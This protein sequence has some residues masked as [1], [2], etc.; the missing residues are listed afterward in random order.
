MVIIII[1]IISSSS[2]TII[3]VSITRSLRRARARVHALASL[4]SRRGSAGSLEVHMLIVRSAD[5]CPSTREG[6]SWEV[7]RD[8]NG[9]EGCGS[10]H[11]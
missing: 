8:V 7:N 5:V 4:T 11:H 3:I 10:K 6:T 2:V 9:S 1:N